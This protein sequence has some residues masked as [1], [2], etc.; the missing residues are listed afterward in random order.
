MWPFF[1]KC[2]TSDYLNY[3]LKHK[4]LQNSGQNPTLHKPIHGNENCHDNETIPR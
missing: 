3:I 4:F 1:N 2:A